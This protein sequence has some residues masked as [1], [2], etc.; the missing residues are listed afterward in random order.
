MRWPSV[1]GPAR[2]SAK[3][4]RSER[5]VS[6]IVVAADGTPPERAATAIADDE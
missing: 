1:V 2:T 4:Y 5:L 3:Q 6:G